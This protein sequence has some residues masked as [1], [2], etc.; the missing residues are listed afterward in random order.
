[1]VSQYSLLDSVYLKNATFYKKCCMFK[2]K[3]KEV[4]TDAQIISE[5]G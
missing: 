3:N 2:N 5:Q 1:M 4:L